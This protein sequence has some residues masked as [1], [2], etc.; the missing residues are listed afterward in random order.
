MFSLFQLDLPFVN[1]GIAK[2]VEINLF[3][4]NSADSN[5]YRPS[6]NQTDSSASEKSSLEDSDDEKV[7]VSPQP[8]SQRNQLPPKPPNQSA[9]KTRNK[10]D[11]DNEYDGQL[12]DNSIVSFNSTSRRNSF[13]S[14]NHPHQASSVERNNDS[15]KRRSVSPKMIWQKNFSFASIDF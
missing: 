12:Q 7:K 4:F 5:S 14:K 9:K 10:E 15:R 8:K 1:F 6:N 3:S 11:S 13:S 2:E